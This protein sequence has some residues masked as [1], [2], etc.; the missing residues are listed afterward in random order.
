[1]NQLLL[2]VGEF[3][4]Q[5]KDGEVFDISSLPHWN[6]QM[7]EELNQLIKTHQ[8]CGIRPHN[9]RKRVLCRRCMLPN[10]G[11]RLLWGLEQRFRGLRGRT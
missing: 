11:Q 6:S 4:K 2:Q 1:M 7:D 10:D 8:I 5:K 9:K 3:I